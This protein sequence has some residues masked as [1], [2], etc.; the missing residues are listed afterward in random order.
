MSIQKS[1]S[2]TSAPHSLGTPPEKSAVRPD[3]LAGMQ[4]AFCNQR[5]GEAHLSQ[6]EDGIPAEDY[7][8]IGLPDDWVVE[9]DSEG[10]PT[11][12]HPDVVA[13]YWR[14]ARFVALTQLNQMPLDG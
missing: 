5:T 14:D 1:M 10:K 6:T 12:L 7:R 3:F 4:P 9:R 2:T 8:F 13:G 11:A